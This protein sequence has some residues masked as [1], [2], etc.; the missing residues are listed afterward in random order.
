MLSNT[1]QQQNSTFN[2]KRSHPD[3]PFG[4]R[5][6]SILPF[7]YLSCVYSANGSSLYPIYWEK[8][9]EFFDGEIPYSLKTLPEFEAT[10]KH[11]CDK[12]Y[13]WKLY[14]ICPLCGHGIQVPDMN[15][16]GKGISRKCTNNLCGLNY[17]EELKI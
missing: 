13:G 8:V 7:N 12:L 15:S 5:A 10:L 1:T 17:F 9:L 11:Y 16:T 4:S 2:Y 6:D 3:T 14:E